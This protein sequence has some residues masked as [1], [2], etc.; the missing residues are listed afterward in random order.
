MRQLVI[1]TATEALSV[2]L[3]TDGELTD[4]HH[5]IAGR[6]HAEKLIPIIAKMDNGGRADSIIV[7]SGPGSF[8]G[9]RVGLAAARALAYGWNVPLQGYDSLTLLAAMARAS[10]DGTVTDPASE[11]AVAITGGHGELFWRLFDPDTLAP[12]MELRSTPISLLAEELKTPVVYGSGAA[13]LIDARGYGRAVPLHPD[14]RHVPLMPKDAL[15]D[16]MAPIYGRGAD[17][18]PL[19]ARKG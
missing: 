11:L 14:A 9:V 3:F 13:A 8:T 6:G 4:F 10:V 16:D 2:A 17:A 15:R 7:D 19:A 12:Q 1:D 18:V 5:E